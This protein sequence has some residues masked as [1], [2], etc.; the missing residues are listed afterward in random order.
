MF[1]RRRC[2]IGEPFQGGRQLRDPPTD[3]VLQR[4][5]RQLPPGDPG[6]VRHLPRHRIKEARCGVQ[7]GRRLLE[8]ALPGVVGQRFISRGAGGRRQRQ[9]RFLPGEL[10][11]D[12]HPA[13]RQAS[14]RPKTFFSQAA[15]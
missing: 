10:Q 4:H 2:R 13:G 7:D 5:H 8:E 14:V 6:S 3:R 12:H 9:H 1:L 15:G 11:A